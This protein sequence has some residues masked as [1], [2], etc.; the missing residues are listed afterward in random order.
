VC[1]I[2]E[3]GC[4][5]LSAFQCEFAGRWPGDVTKLSAVTVACSPLPF[6]CNKTGIIYILVL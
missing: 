5:S 1:G 2:T 4:L 6:Y 3:L